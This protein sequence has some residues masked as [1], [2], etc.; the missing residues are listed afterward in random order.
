M[1]YRREVFANAP[2]AYVACEVRFPLTPNLTGDESLELLAAAFADTLPIPDFMSVRPA[3]EMEATQDIERGLRFLN[4]ARTA[5]IAVTRRSLVTE[6]TSY[7]RWENFKPLVLRAIE[8]VADTKRII[9]A[10]R[11]GLRYINEVRV[12]GSISDLSGWRG[13][14]SDDVLGRVEPISG[15]RAESSQTVIYLKGEKLNATARYAST[16]TP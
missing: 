14:I 15:Y 2:L 6:V 5:S 9:G 11:I 7:S 16:T 4:K 1:S 10:E 3:G 8:A 13:W 12:P